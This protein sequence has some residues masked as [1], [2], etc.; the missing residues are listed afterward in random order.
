MYGLGMVIN[1]KNLDVEISGKT[2]LA[3][4][5]S[6]NIAAA[7]A[8]RRSIGAN[9]TWGH[10]GPM[11]VDITL[12]GAFSENWAWLANNGTG[13]GASL[14]IRL[15]SVI[16]TGCYLTEIE[17]RGESHGVIEA[18]ATFRT[19]SGPSGAPSGFVAYTGANAG[20]E[21]VYHSQMSEFN[22]TG[23]YA[24]EAFTYRVQTERVPRFVIGES[25][26]SVV[27]LARVEKELTLQG[28]NV[29]SFVSYSGGSGVAQFIL[30]HTNS[31]IFD[32]FYVY[33][34]GEV[35]NQDFSLGDLLD[36]SITIKEFIR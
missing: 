34:S 9:P 8:S 35:S 17:L 33:V 31:T 11:Q 3:E 10:D 1:R 27:R 14:P 5:A 28:R 18:A 4:S 19:W 6:M 36:A 29:P 24:P 13:S 25:A 22:Q 21:S 30:N 16:L 23:I 20:A 12:R 2:I 15:G 26:P 32:E 7:S